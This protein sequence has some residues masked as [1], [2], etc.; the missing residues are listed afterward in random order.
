MNCWM[1]VWVRKDGTTQ[2]FMGG[3]CYDS[4]LRALEYCNMSNANLNELHF[5]YVVEMTQVG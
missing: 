4:R 1:I 3:V 2:P 5:G